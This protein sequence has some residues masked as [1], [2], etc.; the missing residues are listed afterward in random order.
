[1]PDRRAVLRGALLGGALAAAPWVRRARAEEPAVRL[2]WFHDFPPYSWAEED[3][4]IRGL[5]VD[6]VEEA[7]GRRM[8]LRVEHVGL[9]WARAQALVR[10]GEAD[11]LC[12]LPTAERHTFTIPSAEPVLKAPV[13]IFA[14]L[15]GA[16]LGDLERVA[17]LEDLR[18]FRIAYY[19]GS[20]WVRENL[21]NR[22]LTLVEAPDV[23]G[24]LKLVARGRAD[25]TVET[26]PVLRHRLL[27]LG[28][29]GELTE[30]AP[31]LDTI[32]FHLCIAKTSPH[33]GKLPGFDAALKAMHRDGTYAK[34]TRALG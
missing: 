15:R 3:G 29:E 1:M 24:A 26:A 12:T 9:P 31:V 6:V 22:D 13:R 28:L 4:A 27:Q 34:L 14:G 32:P 5:F 17:R 25:A 30:L 8:G 23:A 11:A 19:V 21:G 2:A 16:R 7:L 10:A 20:G 33:L 18:G